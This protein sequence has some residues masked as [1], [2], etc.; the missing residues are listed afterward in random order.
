[1]RGSQT[2]PI[3]NWT[4]YK[5]TIPLRLGKPHLLCPGVTSR[6]TLLLHHERLFQLCTGLD[7]IGLRWWFPVDYR[8]QD[9]L[10]GLNMVYQILVSNH[11][12]TRPPPVSNG[13]TH[14]VSAKSRRIRFHQKSVLS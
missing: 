4:R 13:D 1:M 8:F 7:S 14:A 11:F 3:I 12:P 6:E 5:E 9:S 2:S 10:R